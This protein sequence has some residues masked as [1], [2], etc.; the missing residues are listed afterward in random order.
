MKLSF[1]LELPMDL[2]SQYSLVWKCYI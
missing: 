1:Y 2:A